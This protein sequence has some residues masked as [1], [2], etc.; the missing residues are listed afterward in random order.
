MAKQSSK[1][2]NG[3]RAGLGR[4]AAWLCPGKDDCEQYITDSGHGSVPGVSSRGSSIR[5]GPGRAPWDVRT[6]SK[7]PAGYAPYWPPVRRR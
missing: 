6:S 1:V 2:G 7:P 4:L 5:S 3:K